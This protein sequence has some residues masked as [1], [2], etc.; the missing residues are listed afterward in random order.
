[1]SSLPPDPAADHRARA[2]IKRALWITLAAL[3]FGIGVV[4]IFLPLLP[5]T[6]FMLL[7]VICASRGSKR[8]ERWIRRNRF[9]G[10][11]IRAW[12]EERAI[13]LPAKVVSIGMMF[14][15][16]WVIWIHTG[17]N[18]VFWVLLMVLI[19]VGT[20]VATRPLPSGNARTSNDR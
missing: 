11:L 2:P 10:P 8:F 7:S 15:S 5:A 20:F 16:A 9:A 17:F 13:P 19:L 1:M 14:F 6:D 18:W 3:C 4:G 12:E